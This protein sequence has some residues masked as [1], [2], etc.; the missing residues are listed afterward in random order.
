MF[1]FGSEFRVI[2]HE[3]AVTRYIMEFRVGCRGGERFSVVDQYFEKFG[4]RFR[5]MF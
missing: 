4:F 3:G 5:V 2:R 1:R